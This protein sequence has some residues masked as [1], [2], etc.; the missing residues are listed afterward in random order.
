MTAQSAR[1]LLGERRQRFRG[2]AELAGVPPLHMEHD[3]LPEFV[4][5]PIRAW[6]AALGPSPTQRRTARAAPWGSALIAGK[7]SLGK[8]GAC[9]WF[10]T[11]VFARCGFM[12]YP[13]VDPNFYR[14]PTWLW[15]PF[16]RYTQLSERR[17]W[18][19]LDRATRVELLVLDDVNGQGG[20][21]GRGFE[22]LDTLIEERWGHRRT[23]LVTTNLPVPTER[24]P[25]VEG[26]FADLYPRVFARL[27]ERGHGPGLVIPE[28][29]RN[30]RTDPARVDDGG[31]T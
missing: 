11:A 14:A 1:T 13:D 31:P 23:T 4:P 8:S 22:Q 19:T 6:A 9:V 26:T 24:H 15:L 29:R 10:G 30:L 18:K 12:P 25:Q 16:G 20:R 17:D 28:N 27:T 21:Y 2:Y 7:L 3:L 5:G